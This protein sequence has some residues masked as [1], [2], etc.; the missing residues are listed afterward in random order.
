MNFGLRIRF[1]QMYKNVVKKPDHKE[2]TREKLLRLGLEMAREHG[3][4]A[5]TVRGLARKARVNLGTFV[6]HF[7]T[8]EAFVAQ[9]L[10]QWYAPLFEHLQ[11]SA[12]AEL[13]PLSALRAMIVEAT[14]FIQTSGPLI[15]QLVLDAL[16]GEK[17][18]GKFLQKM[19]PRH[20]QLI[21]ETIMAAQK[22]GELRAGEPYQLFL[23]I[24]GAVGM[25]AIVRFILETSR[26]GALPV[27]PK[28]AGLA[29]SPEG[30]AQRL[31]WVLKG[32]RPDN[33]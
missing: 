14:T 25:P 11:I 17:S 10:E 29:A 1:I 22:R 12:R 6:Y 26:K 7:R 32:L 15:A 13:T 9:L 18:V 20:P 8:R 27:S 21:Y 2:G 31:D 4:R 3:L 16:A 5:L 33:A 19:Y 28:L 23:C 30:F 24:V